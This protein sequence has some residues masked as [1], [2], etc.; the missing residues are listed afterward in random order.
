MATPLDFAK[1]LLNRLGI[2]QSQNRLVGLVAFAG[3][4]GGHW[5][6]GARYNPFNT[7]LGMPGAVDVI[8]AVK[9]YPN[10]DTG[11]EAT[12]RTMSQSNMRPIMDALVADASP[13]AFLASITKTPWCPQS[14]PGCSAY[15]NANAMALYQARA[16][17]N[18]GGGSL[19]TAPSPIAWVKQHPVVTVAVILFAVGGVTYYFRP[20]LFR[21]IPVVGRFAAAENPVRGA[22]RRRRS[23]ASR[24]PGAGGGRVQTLLFPRDKFTPATATAWARSHGF[25]SGKIDVTDKYVRIRQ[26]PPGGRMRTIQFQNTPIRAVVRFG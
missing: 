4:E 24:A 16:N 23:T 19:T 3:E 11:I 26:L 21:K 12:A 9:A 10:W 5:H 20:D 13:Q 15:E 17:E 8:G 6:N 1:A 14:S 7:T 22:R 25:K 18:D 2:P